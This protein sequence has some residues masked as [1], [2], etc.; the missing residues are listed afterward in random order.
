MQQ[1]SW[2]KDHGQQQVVLLFNSLASSP[3]YNNCKLQNKYSKCWIILYGFA[4]WLALDLYKTIHGSE[5]TTIVIEDNY[6][7]LIIAR[8]SPVAELYVPKAWNTPGNMKPSE[9]I[10]K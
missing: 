2:W 3:I 6:S 7:S 4:I 9:I 1:A 5:N 10:V 8:G